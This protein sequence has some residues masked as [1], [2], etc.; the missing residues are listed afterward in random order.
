MSL[1]LM[2]G[3]ILFLKRFYF[4]KQSASSNILRIFSLR[5]R[6]FLFLKVLFVVLGLRSCERAFSRDG[7]RGLFS[8]GGARRGGGSCR[9]WAL[10]ARALAFVARRL[11]SSDPRVGRWTP[12]YHPAR[13]VPGAHLWEGW[14][15]FSGGLGR[16]SLCP[17]VSVGV[18]WPVPSCK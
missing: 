4:S 10:G 9:A 18:P 13:E 15:A 8:G 17:T 16:L 6:V 12:K 7:G 11:S 1:M 14:L 5:F 2:R 3:E